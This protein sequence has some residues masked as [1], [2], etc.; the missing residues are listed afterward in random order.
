MIGLE[1]G[2]VRLAS[3]TTEW[4]E[5]FQTEKELLR[6]ALGSRAL[7]IQHIG[8]TAIPH[9]AAKPIIDIAIAVATDADIAA[10]IAPLTTR[11]ATSTHMAVASTVA[12]KLNAMPQNPSSSTSRRPCASES[13]PRNGE[14]KKFARLKAKVT[15]PYQ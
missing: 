3:Y 10:C 7:D 13:A 8:S 12:R 6:A 5:Y 4:D 9:L 15:T 11:T 14:L 1:S 2:L